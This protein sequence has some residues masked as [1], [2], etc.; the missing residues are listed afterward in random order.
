VATHERYLTVR[1]AAHA[2]AAVAKS[3]RTRLQWVHLELALVLV[4][5][6]GR[7]I[8]AVRGLRWQ[9]IRSDP[10]AI[11]WRK[12]FDKQLCEQTIPIP[13]SLADEIRALRAR[14]GAFGDDWLFPQ[15]VG[16]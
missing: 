7:R 11:T 10:P 3:R 12:E 6:T 4:E 13:D 14:L 1:A 9:D 8:G 5:A 15:S 2:L 16:D